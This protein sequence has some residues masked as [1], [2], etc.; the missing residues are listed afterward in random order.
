MID[1]A[2]LTRRLGEPRIEQ[3][4]VARWAGR[5][6]TSTWTE[7]E[8]EELRL[9]WE[10]RQAQKAAERAARLMT[11]DQLLAVPRGG[12]VTDGSNTY[13]VLGR[14]NFEVQDG[15]RLGVD[16]LLDAGEMYGELREHTP[17]SGQRF[18]TVQDLEALDED[19]QVTDGDVTW[20]ATGATTA[21][22]T[23]AWLVESETG[24][25]RWPEDLA[26]IGVWP[27]HID[28]EDD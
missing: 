25:K 23:T 17:P 20:V 3:Y 13:L 12:R 19:D 6:E 10:A 7:E 27:V 24:G 9:R 1:I 11:R 26:W 21:A 15:D 14:G 18:L 8:A 5:P 28:G 2:E 4:N 22:G 16:D